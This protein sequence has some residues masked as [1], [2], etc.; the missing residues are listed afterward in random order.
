MKLILILLI[1][2]IPTIITFS[3]NPVSS[4]K[5]LQKGKK[6]EAFK[7]FQEI[8]KKDSNSVIAN[9][10][11]AL[12][13]SVASFSQYDL[14]L[15][16]KY[17]KRAN[18]FITSNN[19]NELVGKSDLKSIEKLQ[20]K[21]Y[22]LLHLNDSILDKVY[23]NT[24]LKNEKSSW[25]ISV[26]NLKSFIQ[27]YPEYKEIQNA[28]DELERH[29][30]NLA[31]R[32]NT[33]EAYQKFIIDYP[34]SENVKTA[35]DRIYI[36]EF[37]NAEKINS[38]ESFKY[39]IEK[40]PN[41]KQVGEA[42]Q[43]IYTLAFKQAEKNNT[44]EAY[45]KFINDYP[46]SKESL[47]AQ[48]KSNALKS[49]DIKSII[50]NG[51]IGF[52][53]LY[54]DIFIQPQYDLT[55]GFKEGYAF[56]KKNGLWGVIDITG[57]EV[58]PFIYEEASS[59][60]EGLATVKLNNKWG[61]INYYGNEIVPFISDVQRD[62]NEGMAIIVQNGKWGFVNQR[63]ELA[64]DCKYDYVDDFIEGLSSVSLKIDNEDNFGYIN[65]QGKVIVPIKYKFTSNFKEGLACVQDWDLNY[66]Y[67]NKSGIEIISCKYL[68]AKS[69]SEGLACVSTESGWGYINPY[70][71][72]VIPDKFDEA[73]DFDNGL[74]KVVRDGLKGYIDRT[75]KVIIPLIY[76]MANQSF[77][78][79]LSNVMKD[80]KWCFIDTKGN[81]VLKCNYQEVYSFENGLACVKKNY[82]YG[83]INHEGREIVPCIY[84][85]HLSFNIF[86]S[87][88]RAWNEK[89]SGF[90]DKKGNF[91]A[92]IYDVKKTDINTTKESKDFSKSQ[93]DGMQKVNSIPDWAVG[94][95][96]LFSTTSILSYAILRL[97][98]NLDLGFY[99]SDSNKTYSS[100]ITAFINNNTNH[101][102]LEFY[103]N[104]KK[105]SVYL[106][107]N[108]HE[109]FYYLGGQFWKL[110]KI[111]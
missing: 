14:E 27:K 19:W 29:E 40:Y 42:K 81:T 80:G 48:Q 65:I 58:V 39:F 93:N 111:M 91:L 87:L 55:K 101:Y 71:E 75:G 24:I 61:F 64:I 38:I 46:N 45:I 86:G 94:N 51:K 83:A 36:L 32:Q 79:G 12:L 92:D 102:R 23:Q 7:A 73:F 59:F 1:V 99:N 84:D 37:I 76:T 2:T 13:F 107:N 95:W 89:G 72:M 4:F 25:E 34:K 63:G 18:I 106:D 78:E 30:F 60:N 74:A 54:E 49:K 17:S 35:I 85:N 43:S 82:K 6:E 62:F 10:A 96:K 16:Y 97:G 9:Y 5:D 3:R 69:F 105:Q 50:Y 41:A 20:I 33:V 8:S 110:K 90:I 31:G 52:V 47:V 21:P 100:D 109:L 77:S 66:G 104:N 57:K 53:D 98:R 88:S 70:G 68:E 44:K 15:S 67:L 28:Q 103:I 22:N 11:F 56:V 26:E 108:S